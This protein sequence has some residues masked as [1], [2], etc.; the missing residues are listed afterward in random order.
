MRF[1]GMIER[2]ADNGVDGFA[3]RVDVVFPDINQAVEFSIVDTVG[4]AIGGGGGYRFWWLQ[5]CLPVEALVGEIREI[6]SAVANQIGRASVLMDPRPGIQWHRREN[7]S[8]SIIVQAD[9]RAPSS[10]GWPALDPIHVVAVKG[11]LSEL[12]RF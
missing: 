2:N 10:F 4:V 1:T 12:D 5:R 7:L 8:C 3:R 11:D 9:N 6:E